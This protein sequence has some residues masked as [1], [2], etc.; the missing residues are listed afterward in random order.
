MRPMWWPSL[1][2]YA[3]R[4]HYFSVYKWNCAIHCTCCSMLRIIERAPV[5]WCLDWCTAEPY[6]SNASEKQEKIEIYSLWIHSRVF[7]SRGIT[8]RR[9]LLQS[10]IVRRERSRHAPISR[11]E[12][13]VT[14]NNVVYRRPYCLTR[15]KCEFST[16]VQI[17]R[18]QSL[19]AVLCIFISSI[20]SM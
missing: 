4:R 5:Q 17:R 7:F 6:K 20:F 13:S 11:E 15:D 16:K 10:E 3:I 14:F 8:L 19:A 9:K 18:T 2:H 12:V 1:M